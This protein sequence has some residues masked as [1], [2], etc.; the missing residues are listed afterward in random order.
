MLIKPP[1]LD[2]DDRLGQPGRDLRER[3]VFAIAVAET[4]ERCARAVL[5]RDLG[6]PLIAGNA[7]EVCEVEA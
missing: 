7:L 5:Q 1:V 6:L 4:R 2:G 3:Q